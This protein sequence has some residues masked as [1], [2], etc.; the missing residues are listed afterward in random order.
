M[1]KGDELGRVYDNTS[2][3]YPVLTR[4]SSGSNNFVS[5]ISLPYYIRSLSILL[6]K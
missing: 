5:L 4:R 3:K 2:T 1:G 6:F